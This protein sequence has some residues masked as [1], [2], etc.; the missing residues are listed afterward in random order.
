MVGL[1][2]LPMVLFTLPM[3]ALLL[4]EPPAVLQPGQMPVAALSAE[5]S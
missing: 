1:A 3:A 2:R 4:S 5:I